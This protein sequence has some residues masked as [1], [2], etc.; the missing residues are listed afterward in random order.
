[1]NM[2]PPP[3]SVPPQLLEHSIKMRDHFASYIEA[4]RKEDYEEAKDAL[5]K[6]TRLVTLSFTACAELERKGNHA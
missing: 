2:V 4:I 3:S 5:V 6:I 1:M